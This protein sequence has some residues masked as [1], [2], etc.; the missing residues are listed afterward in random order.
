MKAEQQRIAGIGTSYQDFLCKPA[1]QHSLSKVHVAVH[2][3]RHYPP[4]SFRM[5]ERQWTTA[6]A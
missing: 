2:G 4:H 1:E 3:A 6:V 5:A